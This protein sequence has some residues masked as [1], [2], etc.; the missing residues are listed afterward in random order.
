[1]EN[2]AVPWGS[3]CGVV[4]MEL[5]EP[6]PEAV[7][8]AYLARL[9][10]SRPCH[11]NVAALQCLTTAHLD[12]VSYDNI[13]IHAGRP[14]PPLD[15]AS[16]ASRLATKGRGGYCFTAVSAF[17]ALLHTLGFHVSLH[18]SAVGSDPPPAEKWGNHVVLMVHFDSETYVADIGLGEG[19]CGAFPLAPNIW[20]EHG[21]TFALEERQGSWWWQNDAVH[22]FPGFTVN[23]NTSVVS[24]EEF[25]AYHEYYWTNPEAS[26]VK[27]GVILHRPTPQG[28]LSLHSCTL[29]RTH[30]S[31]PGGYEIIATLASS[32]EWFRL[33]R[34]TFLL[35]LADLSEEERARLWTRAEQDHKSWLAKH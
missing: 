15:F 16:A 7:V 2:A 28:V 12:R 6:L 25:Q 20:Q 11:L 17:A 27:S 10:V 1:M 34:E 19:P 30:P 14:P 35:D 26:Y 32:D 22:G 23:T 13:D 8:E 4:C 9:G 3:A 18:T 24:V 33:L 29:R 5:P 31:T 21:F